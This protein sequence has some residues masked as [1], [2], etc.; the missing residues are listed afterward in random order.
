MLLSFTST[1][2]IIKNSF[3]RYNKIGNETG[4]YSEDF[5][6]NHDALAAKERIFDDTLTNFNFIWKAMI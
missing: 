6:Q 3:F 1:N 4:L 5:Y 2:A